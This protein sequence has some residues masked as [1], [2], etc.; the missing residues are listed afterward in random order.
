MSFKG[1]KGK[2]NM[3]TGEEGRCTPEIPAYERLKQKFKFWV[4]QPEFQAR[5]GYINY[6]KKPNKQT[7]PSGLFIYNCFCC[8]KE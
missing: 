3:N 5:L 7:K 6:H 1:P 8:A 2:D 4:R